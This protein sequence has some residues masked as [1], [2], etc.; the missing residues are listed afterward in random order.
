[1]SYNYQQLINY[2][3]EKYGKVEGSYFINEN[4]K[5]KN[6]KIVRSSEGLFIHHV[7]EDTIGNLSKPK[8]AQ[9]APWEYQKGE[10]LVYCDLVEHTLLHVLIS[11][12]R[13]GGH[14]GPYFMFTAPLI[15]DILRDYEFKLE[16]QKVIYQKT[17]PYKKTLIK[18]YKRVG[19]SELLR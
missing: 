15:N 3:N 8:N 17:K 14:P 16:Y 9:L 18:L 6:R 10:N 2:L 1:M 7:K 19:A 13:M 11:E 5:S 4:C 12:E